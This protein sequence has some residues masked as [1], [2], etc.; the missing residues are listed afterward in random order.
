MDEHSD[1]RGFW[2]REKVNIFIAGEVPDTVAIEHLAKCL[3]AS[4][5]KDHIETAV[6]KAVHPRVPVTDR[7]SGV[8]VLYLLEVEGNG[9]QCLNIGC[10]FKVND[11]ITISNT[12]ILQCHTFTKCIVCVVIPPGYSIGDLCYPPESFQILSGIG[13]GNSYQ[14]VA[15]PDSQAYSGGSADGPNPT[16][17]TSPVPEDNQI[18]TPSLDEEPIRQVGDVQDSQIS[19]TLPWPVKNLEDTVPKNSS[20]QHPIAPTQK[21]ERPTVKPSCKDG[22]VPK[23]VHRAPTNME[24]DVEM[25]DV[26]GQIV[27]GYKPPPTGGASSSKDPI[28]S[29]S[30]VKP[31]ND[32]MEIDS[33]GVSPCQP[34]LKQTRSDHKGSERKPSKETIVA[35]AS[36]QK[37]R[38]GATQPVRSTAVPQQPV[39]KNGTTHRPPGITILQHSAILAKSR[40]RNDQLAGC[41]TAAANHVRTGKR[42][43]RPNR[44]AAR[45]KGLSSTKVSSFFQKAVETPIQR[46]PH[47]FDEVDQSTHVPMIIDIEQEN[48]ERAFAEE[49]IMKQV[50]R[51]ANLKWHAD[52]EDDVRSSAGSFALDFL[53]SMNG[54][55]CYLTVAFRMLAKAPWTTSMVCVHIRQ[56]AIYAIS[57]GWFVNTQTTHGICFSRAELALAAGTFLGDLTPSLP[58]DTDYPLFLLIQEL[59]HN[60]AELFSIGSAVCKCCGGSRKVPVPTFA[61]EH[62][63]ASSSWKSPRH[64]LE[65]WLYTF[66][67]DYQ[68]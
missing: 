60:C 66:S 1:V 3:P 26:S 35:M 57:Q 5:F 29:Y 20:N 14:D 37:P 45:P 12:E 49:N 44:Q 24:Q 15:D 16:R 54:T 68:T 51:E 41:G 6:A 22:V 17:A 65:K 18:G 21:K 32:D 53:K 40:E 59:P 28:E 34:Q 46:H 50:I 30:S 47:D 10:A 48:L 63:W 31:S 13:L 64:C 11:R 7:R 9:A 8:P 61:T 33:D 4:E 67:L 38:P 36:A 43:D 55:L 56:A 62:S 19:A 25:P 42:V 23:H 2:F 39:A 27:A 52:D 58:D